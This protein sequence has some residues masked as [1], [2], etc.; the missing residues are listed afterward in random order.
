[1]NDFCLIT[2]QISRMIIIRI[3]MKIKQLRMMTKMYGGASLRS[4]FERLEIPP[5]KNVDGYERINFIL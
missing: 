3:K 5:G 4:L 1:M 2:L